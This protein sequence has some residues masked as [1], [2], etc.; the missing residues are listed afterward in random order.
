[1]Y[2]RLHMIYFVVYYTYFAKE[3]F[4][5]KYRAVY[6]RPVDIMDKMSTPAKKKMAFYRLLPRNSQIFDFL[7]CRY[8]T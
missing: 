5:F 6:I 8:Y 1:M 3:F 4:A 2:T 7:K